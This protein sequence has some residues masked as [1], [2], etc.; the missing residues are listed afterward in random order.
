M[1]SLCLPLI[2]NIKVHLQ[3]FNFITLAILIIIDI[4][5][6]RLNSIIA[7]RIYVM[8]NWPEINTVLLDMDGTLLDLNFD[9]EFWLEHVPSSIAKKKNIS[10]KDAKEEMMSKYHS[11]SGQIEWYCL[12]YWQKELD[13]PIIELKDEISHLIKVRPDTIPFLD[14]LK[15]AGKRIILVTNAHPDSLSLK[16]EKTQIDS[17]IDELISCH[18]FGVTKESQDLWRQLQNRLKFKSTSTLFVDDSLQVL[19]AAKEFGIK[20][21]L[22]VANPNSQIPSKSID[23]FLNIEDYRTLLKEIQ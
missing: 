13:L 15:A 17:H 14:A 5:S 20:H 19:L 18:T 21:I 2:F 6:G 3:K 11:V 10:L 8:I 22:A 4:I 12:D 9:T 23:G 7:I 1:D 16:I